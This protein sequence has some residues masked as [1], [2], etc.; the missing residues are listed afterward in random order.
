MEKLDDVWASKIWDEPNFTKDF[1]SCR[2]EFEISQFT[3]KYFSKEID[4]CVEQIRNEWKYVLIK[5]SF[6]F[7]E[8]KNMMLQGLDNLEQTFRKDIHRIHVYR[9]AHYKEQGLH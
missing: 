3:K 2:N 5:K 4:W 8:D 1:A 6:K 9:H 7:A